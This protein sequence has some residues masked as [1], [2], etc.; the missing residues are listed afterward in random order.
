MGEIEREADAA[1]ADEHAA[2]SSVHAA[3]RR[4]RLRAA[5]GVVF[6]LTATAGGF[7]AREMIVEAVNRDV[8]ER[9][10]RHGARFLAKP[11]LQIGDHPRPSDPES[12]EVTWITLDDGARW[13]V[14]SRNEA[15]ATWVAARDVATKRV[16]VEGPGVHLV[17]RARVEALTPGAA[18]AYQLRRNGDV[19]FNANARA[20][21]L[22][23]DPH[24]FV[25]WGDGGA[26]TDAQRSVALEVLKAGPEYTVIV[27]DIVYYKGRATEYLNKFFPVENADSAAAAVGA[28]LLRS[29]I[30]IPVPGNH[31][32]LESELDRSP[33]ALAYFYYWSVP[34]NGL[35]GTAAAPIMPVLKGTPERVRAFRA[36]AGDAYP[37][38]ANYAFDYGGAHWTV[39]DANR[40]TDWTDPARRDWL[41]RELD[42]PAARNAD[43][44]FV[45][46]HQP[47]FQSS[48]AHADEQHMRVI[49][50]LLEKY[51]VDV[52]FTGH[53]HNY[54]RTKP[55]RFRAV[56]GENGR[57]VADSGRVAGEFTIDERYDGKANT[58]PDGVIHLV[59]GAGGARLYDTS[60]RLG[61]RTMQP[62]LAAYRS[63]VHSFTVVDL[64]PRRFVARQVASTGEVIDEFTITR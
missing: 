19:V 62:Y 56:P 8:V 27:G 50:D 20:R 2:G 35:V 7:G 9:A 57:L 51:H 30:L 49:S 5:I 55:L 25:V 12:L 28:P 43:W 18:F 29:T 39:L 34:R 41:E 26:D 17:W 64:E 13:S 1:G 40:Y 11:Y 3:G 63:D 60:S 32:L 47:A 38:A 14:E 58:R 52:V 4:T 23:D 54:Q 16:N 33:D 21:R 6:A 45:A 10:H 22:R 37:V 15:S 53:V 44:R 24:R 36:A 42:S 48:R 46:F 31:D 61:N 59:T